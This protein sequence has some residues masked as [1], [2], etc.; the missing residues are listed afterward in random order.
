[1]MKYFFYIR[2]ILQVILNGYCKALMKT[3]A[4]L[5]GKNMSSVD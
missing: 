2:S 4:L 3:S 1:M 5:F